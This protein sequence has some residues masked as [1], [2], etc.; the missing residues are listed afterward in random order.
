M[1]QIRSIFQG[2]KIFKIK[3]YKN[4]SAHFQKDR[5]PHRLKIL[6]MSQGTKVKR[7]RRHQSKKLE[8]NHR[9][10]SKKSGTNPRHQNKRHHQRQLKRLLMCQGIVYFKVDLSNKGFQPTRNE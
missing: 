8:T 2:M 10:Q 3:Q 6:Q 7:N 9:L 5:E 4:C 1:L